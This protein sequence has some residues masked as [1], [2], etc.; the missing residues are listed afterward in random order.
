MSSKSLGSRLAAA[1][2]ASCSSVAV[3]PA[4]HAQTDN[5]QILIE[6]RG[7]KEP[8]KSRPEYQPYQATIQRLQK[9]GVLE[10]LRLFLSPLR[11][12]ENQTLLLQSDACGSEKRPLRKEGSQRTVTICYEMVDK[13]EK[14]ARK[15]WRQIRADKPEYIGLIRFFARLPISDEAREDLVRRGTIAMVALTQAAPAIFDLLD[16]PLWGHADDAADHLAAFLMVQFGDLVADYTIHGTA[17]FFELSGKTFTGSGFA[18]LNSP[19]AQRYYDYLCIALGGGRL[20]KFRTTLA[21]LLPE[22]RAKQCQREHDKLRK[23]FNLRIMPY[24]DPARLIE[25]RARQ[26]WLLGLADD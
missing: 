4:G 7:D 22:W 26:A 15:S 20:R 19:D 18:P 23:A 3:I 10:K 2:F 14:T 24:I 25:V 16:V 11:L 13:I 8:E 21:P 17:V 9:F 1:I 6:Y 5:S 12:P